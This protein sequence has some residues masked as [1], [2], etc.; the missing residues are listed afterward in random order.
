MIRKITV[1]FIAVLANQS[2]GIDSFIKI[3]SIPKVFYEAKYEV[4]INKHDM[5]N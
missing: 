4:E 1:F 3:D 5:D 2:Y